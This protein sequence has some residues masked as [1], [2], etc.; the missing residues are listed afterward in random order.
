[1]SFTEKEMLKAAVECRQAGVRLAVLCLRLTAAHLAAQRGGSVAWRLFMKRGSRSFS[2]ATLSCC[3]SPSAEHIPV[4]KATS[5]SVE[6]RQ[7]IGV[8]KSLFLLLATSRF[9]SDVVRSCPWR[10]N[11]S[12][13]LR[14]LP[15]S[16]QP[17][18][19]ERASERSSIAQLHTWDV[20]FWQK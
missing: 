12:C 19:R 14:A 1:M 4:T 2:S 8:L 7:K 16:A 3:W 9:N 10:C 6:I 18:G 20:L 13:S 17:R 5:E 15:A 11:H